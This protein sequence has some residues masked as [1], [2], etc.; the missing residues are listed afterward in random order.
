MAIPAVR[1]SWT[2]QRTCGVGLHPSS[3]S[4]FIRIYCH[5]LQRGQQRLRTTTNHTKGEV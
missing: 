3:T 4:R 1:M 5:V 2:H